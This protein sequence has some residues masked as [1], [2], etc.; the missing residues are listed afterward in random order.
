MSYSV[1]TDQFHYQTHLWDAKCPCAW[2]SFLPSTNLVVPYIKLNQQWLSALTKKSR[3]ICMPEFNIKYNLYV[4]SILS[5]VNNIYF[6]IHLYLY[7]NIYLFHDAY[8]YNIKKN[9]DYIST[10]HLFYM[11]NNFKLILS[12]TEYK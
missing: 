11:K 12:E 9:L 10:Y 5:V 1:V 2:K 3:I 7:I 6:N 8:T 4:Y